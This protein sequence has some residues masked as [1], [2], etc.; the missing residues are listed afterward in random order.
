MEKCGFLVEVVSSVVVGKVIVMVCL[1]VYVV[2]DFRFE[3]GNG[4]VVVEILWEWCFECW[5]VVLMGYG[6]IVIVVVVVKI[7]VIDY[8]LKFV[9][10][11]DV[12]NV[13][14]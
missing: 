1:L 6:V 11:N 3:D 2:V 12:I 7:G 10:V 5:V 14:L 4:L 13:F 8:L 9:D